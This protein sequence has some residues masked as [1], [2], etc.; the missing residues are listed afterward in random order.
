MWSFLQS[1]PSFL[2]LARIIGW[3]R[4]N[5]P[6]PRAPQPMKMKRDPTRLHDEYAR[7]LRLFRMETGGDGDKGQ[8]DAHVEGCGPL[9]C[10][11]RLWL[12]NQTEGLEMVVGSF[13]PWLTLH[14]PFSSP[15]RCKIWPFG[16]FLTCSIC[17]LSR[18]PCSPLEQN[19]CWKV[20]QSHLI[21]GWIILIKKFKKKKKKRE[22][23][24]SMWADWYGYGGPWE[25]PNKFGA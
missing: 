8:E 13:Q 11:C 5:C 7:W 3:T 20:V 6:P 22:R 18:V 12:P 4:R 17:T 19:Y 1:Y 15:T 21:A 23:E 25:G 9:V 24:C 14:A 2:F 10:L 16:H